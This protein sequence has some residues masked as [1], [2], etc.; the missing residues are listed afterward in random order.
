MRLV[1]Q[2][3][4]LAELQA[5][6][7]ALKAN[8]RLGGYEMGT[9]CPVGEFEIHLIELEQGDESW[10]Y[11][12][13]EFAQYTQGN[14]GRLID[15]QQSVDS[16][17]ETGKIVSGMISAG[18]DIKHQKERALVAVTSDFTRGALTLIDG[19]HRAIAQFRSFGTI[20]DVP[21]YLCVH[22]QINKWSGWIPANAQRLPS[23]VQ[24]DARIKEDQAVY[25]HLRTQERGILGAPR[26][27]TY[28]L[29]WLCELDDKERPRY[30]LITPAD[31]SELTPTLIRDEILQ[32]TCSGF[33]PN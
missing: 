31:S 4:E 7:Q 17:V 6:D 13:S 22:K 28:N 29:K 1:K 24:Y 5:H 15:V 14:S 23:E 8:I 12:I 3:V 19:S 25:A 33:P 27:T 9:H 18:F 16:H 20:A 30:Q 32:W 11:L 21:V 2:N 10:V 26:A